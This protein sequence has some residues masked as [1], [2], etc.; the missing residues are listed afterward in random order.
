MSNIK[1]GTTFEQDFCNLAKTKGFWA[2]RCNADSSGQPV[3][4][5]LGKNNIGILVD[6]KD[7][8]HDVF[9]FDRVEDNQESSM[10][11]WQETGNKHALFALNLS[12]DI[13]MIPLTF[14]QKLRENGFVALNG[15]QIR[16]IGVTFDAWVE[17]FDENNN[18]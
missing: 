5:L 13:W 15:T 16:Q 3:D 18:K 6:C 11:L 9:S 2:H 1:N 7:C 4:V 10:E 8:R 12:D 14:I 17:R